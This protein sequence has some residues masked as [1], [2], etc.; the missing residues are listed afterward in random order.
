MQNASIPIDW[1]SEQ[2]EAARKRNLSKEYLIIGTVIQDR[3]T[4]TETDLAWEKNVARKEKEL[5]DAENETLSADSE[6]NLR[7]R[8]DPDLPVERDESNQ[9]AEV[10]SGAP[11]TA[12]SLAVL[13]NDISSD[14]NAVSDVSGLTHSSLIR[15]KSNQLS[16]LKVSTSPKTL[17]QTLR[18]IV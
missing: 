4:V 16:L 1:T 3:K 2:V 6:G 13:D 15:P 8:N 11:L 5:D 12:A 18:G 7:E 10:S 17:T 14:L 9:G